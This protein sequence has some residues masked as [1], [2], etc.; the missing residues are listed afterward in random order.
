MKPCRRQTI[1][2]AMAEGMKT[3]SWTTKIHPRASMAIV[4]DWWGEGFRRVESRARA[5]SG[6]YKAGVESELCGL[7]ITSQGGCGSPCLGYRIRNTESE[8]SETAPAKTRRMIYLVTQ[9]FASRPSRGV[10]QTT[11]LK[12]CCSETMAGLGVCSVSDRTGTAAGR[13]A[14]QSGTTA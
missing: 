11:I 5:V 12:L 1:I 6:A 3:T 7:A 13:G 8:G 9:S 4:E 10:S 2:E 14:V